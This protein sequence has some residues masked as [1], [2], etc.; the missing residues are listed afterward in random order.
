M[1]FW[2]QKAIV[3]SCLPLGENRR[4]L[5]PGIKIT[6]GT[7]SEENHSEIN[8]LL[9]VNEA[10]LSLFMESRVLRISGFEDYYRRLLLIHVALGK[11]ASGVIRELNRGISSIWGER[12]S[13]RHPWVQRKVIGEKTETHLFV[14]NGW[15]ASAATSLLSEADFFKQSLFKEFWVCFF[16]KEAVTVRSLGFN[17]PVK[18]FDNK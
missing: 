8:A 14:K 18:S 11:Q 6:L 12:G 16:G 1:C 9:Y 4:F 3:K 10:P 15:G 13:K 17:G 2:L 5:P 7:A